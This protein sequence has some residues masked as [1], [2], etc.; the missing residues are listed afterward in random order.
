MR[1]NLESRLISYSVESY[2]C[3]A[4]ASL[5]IIYLCRMW[6]IDGFFRH[7][8]TFMVILAFSMV[9]PTRLSSVIILKQV[10]VLFSV[11]IVMNS[12]VLF[13]LF[14]SS[15]KSGIRQKEIWH[16]EMPLFYG[17]FRIGKSEN[18]HF[19]LSLFLSFFLFS[20][21]N[22]AWMTYRP[23]PGLNSRPPSL[24]TTPPPRLLDVCVCVCVRQNLSPMGRE[25][26]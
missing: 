16:G 26:N 11:W 12:L 2:S 9:S 1:N 7:M 19:F 6:V 4:S 13:W 24:H 3:T 15:W 17:S 10:T 25:R 18:V 21:K 20:T 5:F 14:L 8:N 23:L 22:V